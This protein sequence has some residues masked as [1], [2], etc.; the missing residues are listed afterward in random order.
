MIARLSLVAL[1]ITLIVA[2]PLAAKDKIKD[3]GAAEAVTCDGVFGRKSSEALVKETFGA[4]NVK[5]G[6]VYGA[7]GMELL[8][9]TVYP[10]DP[11]R[12][13]QFNW[14][15]EENLEYLGSME[16]SPSQ[17]T[18]TG[19]RIG[20][21]VAEVE[22]I[23]GAPFT[24]GGFWWDYGGNATFEKGALVNPEDGCGFWI[25]FAPTEE[26]PSDIDVSPVSGEVTVPS[27]EPLLET[28]DVRVQ[29]INLGYPW[30]EELPQPEY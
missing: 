8:V 16:L 4:E 9:T 29:S 6:I 30:P 7:E 26:Y 2:A 18:P 27:S 17:E 25:R 10:E 3:P 12:V 22:A 1:G 24:V 23:N 21:T 20:M 28:L 14:W 5:T 11:R 15:D 19:V 13:M